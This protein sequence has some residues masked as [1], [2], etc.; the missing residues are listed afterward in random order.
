MA[1]TT[2]FLCSLLLVGTEG[3][4]VNCGFMS[5]DQDSHLLLQFALYQP[6]LFSSLSSREIVAAFPLQFSVLESMNPFLF[7]RTNSTAEIARDAS[8]GYR[9]PSV[10]KRNFSIFHDRKRPF[11]DYDRILTWSRSKCWT[12]TRDRSLHWRPHTRGTVSLP[13]ARS[14]TL[15]FFIWLFGKASTENT[16]AGNS[17]LCNFESRRFI[18]ILFGFEGPCSRN[19][20]AEY[21]FSGNWVKAGSPSSDDSGA[22]RI[23]RTFGKGELARVGSP[24]F[25][26]RRAQ[27]HWYVTSASPGSVPGGNA[28]VILN[29]AMLPTSAACTPR[30]RTC[31]DDFIIRASP[32]SEGRDFLSDTVE[33]TAI[34]HASVTTRAW[35]LCRTSC[36]R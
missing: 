13:A 24:I 5:V 35:L 22:A 16:T 6:R 8:A 9:I 7:A 12:A 36:V 19:S 32:S 1:V 25:I 27:F 4:S 31:C 2:S 29:Y 23:L 28:L 33:T 34:S 26:E 11:S 15:R 30:F 18:L 14:T 10:V 20:S 21:R 17:L 3:N